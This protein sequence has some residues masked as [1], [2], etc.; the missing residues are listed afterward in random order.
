[1]ARFFFLMVGNGTHMDF[2][3]T[4]A[5]EHSEKNPVYYVQYA[6]ARICSILRNTKPLIRKGHTAKTPRLEDLS[7]L[8]LA[9][10]LL[11]FPE[12]VAD[13]ARTRTVNELTGYA[14][15]VAT[16]FHDFYTKFRIIS[17]GTVNLPGLELVQ[18]TQLV[19]QQTLKL[20]G[21]NAPEKM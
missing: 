2:D 19:L 15:Q 4:L 11:E 18:A 21:V 9:K 16:G 13:L 10:K 17:D 5:K 3:L 14:I 20:L 12:L 1:V 8:N 7:A 6:H